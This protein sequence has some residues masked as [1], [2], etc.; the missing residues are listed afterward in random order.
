MVTVK[1]SV[2]HVTFMCW[3]DFSIFHFQ[4][5]L[6]SAGQNTVVSSHLGVDAADV[7]VCRVW[8]CRIIIKYY[9][10][11]VKRCFRLPLGFQSEMFDVFVRLT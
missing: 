8:H 5:I 10:Q 11:Y 2:N 4:I 3:P 6:Q 7:Q 9:K 1:Q